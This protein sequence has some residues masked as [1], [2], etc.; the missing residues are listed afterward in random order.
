MTDFQAAMGAEHAAPAM[1]F[2]TARYPALK[3]RS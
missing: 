3:T 2:I 1:R